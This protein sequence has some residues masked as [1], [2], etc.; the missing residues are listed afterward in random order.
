MS[1]FFGAE[2]KPQP[3]RSSKT[4]DSHVRRERN[5]QADD[6]RYTPGDG[7]VSIENRKEGLFHSLCSVRV[8]YTRTSEL[9]ELLILCSTAPKDNGYYLHHSLEE[10]L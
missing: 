7:Y 5:I 1:G 10:V 8:Q 3:A 6:V 4:G 9:I 2:A